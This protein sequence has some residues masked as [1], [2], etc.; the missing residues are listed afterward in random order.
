MAED[1]KGLKIKEDG[2]GEVLTD[3]SKPAT[4]GRIYVCKT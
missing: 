3:K 4:I 2:L 1:R